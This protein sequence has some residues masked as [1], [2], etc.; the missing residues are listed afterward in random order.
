MSEVLI[1]K[2]READGYF[3]ATELDD[4]E[5]LKVPS[6]VISLSF[7]NSPITDAGISNLPFLDKVRCIDLDSTLI[8]D[9]SMEVITQFKTLEELWIEDIKITDRGFKLLASLP[10]LKYVSFWD[11]EISDDAYNF[12][13]SKLPELKLEG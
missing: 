10:R 1:F 9:K 8:T 6:N 5:L 13:R 11:T 4:C 12:V 3:D 7:E 2:L